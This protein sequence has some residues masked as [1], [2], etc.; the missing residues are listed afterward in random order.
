MAWAQRVRQVDFLHPDG[1][2][3]V[4]IVW[5]LADGGY[6]VRLSILNRRGER[7]L[8]YDW[9][10]GKAAH[11]HHRGSEFPYTFTTVEALVNDFAADV[12]RLRREED[13]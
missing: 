9:H 13:A 2:R 4:Q 11:R 7:R 1:W 12:E 10:H 6:K 5:R 3:E 8:G